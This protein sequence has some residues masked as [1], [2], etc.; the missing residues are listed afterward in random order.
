MKYKITIEK[1]DD[2]TPDPV[3]DRFYE[4]TIE[5]DDEDFI[6]YIINKINE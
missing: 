3:I 5:P 6:K 2:T 4:Q 1:I